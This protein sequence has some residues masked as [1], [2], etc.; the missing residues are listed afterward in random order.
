M[1]WKYFMFAHIMI[2]TASLCRAQ[3]LY[4]LLERSLV[5]LDE[6]LGNELRQM[7]GENHKWGSRYFST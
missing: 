1:I 7:C 6:K 4:Y 5:H 2:V 3:L